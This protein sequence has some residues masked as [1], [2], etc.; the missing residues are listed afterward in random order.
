LWVRPGDYPRLDHLLGQ[1]PALPVIIRLGW[2]RL[3]RDK[4]SSLERKLINYGQ[5]SFITFGPGHL[6]RVKRGK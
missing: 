1:A 3:A 5:K 2:E 6:T 4:H